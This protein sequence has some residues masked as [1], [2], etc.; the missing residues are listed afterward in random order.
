MG[1]GRRN[2]LVHGDGK[3]TQLPIDF[4]QY[5]LLAPPLIC[6]TIVVPAG[7]LFSFNGYGALSRTI[8]AGATA[9]FY[10][11]MVQLA[12]MLMTCAFSASMVR[13]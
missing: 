3:G 11:L 13:A 8:S 5:V 7:L 9:N 2:S 1:S 12:P 10:W 4:T 6:S